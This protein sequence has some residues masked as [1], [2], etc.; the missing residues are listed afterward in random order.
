MSIIKLFKRNNKNTCQWCLYYNAYNWTCDN[1]RSSKD[2]FISPEEK[3]CDLFK[4]DIFKLK[5]S[6]RIQL[7][8]K[9]KLITLTYLSKQLSELESLLITKK[10]LHEDT[11]TVEYDIKSIKQTMYYLEHLYK[12]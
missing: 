5:I 10:L 1:Y 12:L 4:S 7:N 2:I 3:K 8:H 11:T 9:G 6:N